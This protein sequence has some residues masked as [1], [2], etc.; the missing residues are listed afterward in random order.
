MSALTLA[1]LD[2]DRRFDEQQSVD[3]EIARLEAQEIKR[4]G[5][6]GTLFVEMAADSCED[7]DKL[8]RVLY[9]L[10]EHGVDLVRESET[11]RGMLEDAIAQEMGCDD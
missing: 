3:R 8:V 10:A 2:L 6:V 4:Y 1:E 11:F 7:A 5:H 9:E